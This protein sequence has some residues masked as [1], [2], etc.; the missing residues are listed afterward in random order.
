MRINARHMRSGTSIPRLRI[1]ETLTQ[2]RPSM[3]IL[4]IASM[5]ATFNIIDTARLMVGPWATVFGPRQ[6]LVSIVIV[7]LTISLAWMPIHGALAIVSV[8]IIAACIPPTAFTVSMSL[9]LNLLLTISLIAIWNAAATMALVTVGMLATAGIGVAHGDLHLEN[10]YG[11]LLLLLLVAGANFP[12][13]IMALMQHHAQIEKIHDRER[14]RRRRLRVIVGLHDDVANRLSNLSLRLDREINRG[15]S[16]N[17]SIGSG[18][19]SLSPNDATNS[20]VSSDSSPV[21]R[22][23]LQEVDAALASTRRIVSLLRDEAS[24]NQSD[25]PVD[26]AA[27]RH[28]TSWPH[29]LR[30][31]LEHE[32][33]RLEELGI[34]GTMLIDGTL[35]RHMSRRT[36][37]TLLPFLRELCANVGK[38]ADRDKGYVLSLQ[39]KD[40]MIVVSLCDVPRQNDSAS[41]NASASTGIG[42]AHHA[43]VFERLGGDIRVTQTKDQWS[44]VATLP[45]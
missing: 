1:R 33:R 4:L 34:H 30:R 39:E 23:M 25:I 35:S 17:T 7:I 44:L 8:W 36:M 32:Q 29:D 21:L 41:N 45:V 40:S 9:T 22:D 2:R 10:G 11:W 31:T 12:L 3:P 28:R 18:N 15:T 26:N 5:I 43:A 6:A 14:E 19:R 27:S 38:Y 24:Q 42:I 37:A 13:M 20:S 16:A